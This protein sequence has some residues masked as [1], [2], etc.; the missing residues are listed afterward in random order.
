MIKLLKTATPFQADAVA[1]LAPVEK[2]PDE[3]VTVT[4]EVLVVA[5]LPKASSTA[6]VTAGLMA[7]PAVALVGG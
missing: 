6:T 4:A 2:T 7:T 1:V 3:M 5:T